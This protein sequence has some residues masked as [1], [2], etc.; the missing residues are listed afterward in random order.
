MFIKYRN[1][2]ME[3]FLD[4]CK[5]LSGY[6]PGNN[7]SSRRKRFESTKNRETLY[8]LHNPFYEPFFFVDFL[9]SITW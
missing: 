6:K 3:M 2:F 5:W 7:K 1:I 9:T 8:A 4:I